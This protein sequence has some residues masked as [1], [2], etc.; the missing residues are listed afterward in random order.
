ME[1][2]TVEVPVSLKKRNRK[3]G[4]HTKTTR[5]PISNSHLPK[6]R[7][8]HYKSHRFQ[9]KL[10]AKVF[11]IKTTYR[12]R[13][14][15][16]LHFKKKKRARNIWFCSRN[17]KK[18]RKNKRGGSNNS[19]KFN[20]KMHKIDNKPPSNRLPSIALRPACEVWLEM[21]WR[22]KTL[23][24]SNSSTFKFN[25]L[26]WSQSR[27]AVSAKVANKTNQAMI[28]ST[29]QRGNRLSSCRIMSM[30]TK[31]MSSNNSKEKTAIPLVSKVKIKEILRK[32]SKCT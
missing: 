15:R 8:P 18:K 13:K 11:K 24:T 23:C 10:K 29:N 5:K 6:T 20:K 16:N 27:G 22:I 19:N 14:R 12:K 26:L 32:E 31:N 17:N 4:N 25:K 28:I 30:N 7:V 1:A 9:R 21:I 3:S 2:V